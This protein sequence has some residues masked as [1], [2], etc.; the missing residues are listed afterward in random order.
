MA[1]TNVEFQLHEFA[2]YD[3][4]APQG[5]YSTWHALTGSA[6]GDSRFYQFCPAV[7]SV[8]QA[9][10]FGIGYV[11]EPHGR[12]GPLGSVFVQ[13]LGDEDLYRI[14]GASQ[15]TLVPTDVRHLIPPA[16]A[17]GSPVRVSYTDSGRLNI[18]TNAAGPQLLRLRVTDV[19]GWH[20]TIDGHPL[21]LE[22]FSGVMIQTRIPPGHHL[23][24]LHYW[25]VAFTAGLIIS[26]LCAIV[27]LI[28][29]ILEARGR[30]KGHFRDQPRAGIPGA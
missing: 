14:P 29:T 3:P 24:Q 5:Y 20:A 21:P 18:T 27:L 15:A 12:R 1:E 8:D 26:I 30:R 10:L 19:P 13:S 7:T 23:V 22:E 6:G 9:R 11:L 4:L 17:N 25:P 16:S 28:A 2:L